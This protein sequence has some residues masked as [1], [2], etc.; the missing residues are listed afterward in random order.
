MSP[1]DRRRRPVGQHRGWHRA[2]PPHRRRR[3]LWPDLPP[4]HDE[5]RQEDGQDREGRAFPRP[6]H[7]EPLRLLPVLAQRRRR[8]RGALPPHVHL[9]ARR[10]MQG[11]WNAEG[12]WH[13]Q[14][15]GA[16]GLRGHLAHPWQGRG[17]QGFRGGQGGLRKRSRRRSGHRRGTVQGYSPR[18]S[19]ERNQ[20]A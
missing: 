13:Q 1:P 16:I 10:G 12:R 6:C 8:R 20:R 2:N 15:Q 7:H 3:M 4:C 19:R 9:P 18:R 14:G 11:P 5:R 17:G